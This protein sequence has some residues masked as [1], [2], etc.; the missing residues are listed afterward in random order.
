MVGLKSTSSEEWNRLDN[1]LHEA[2]GYRRLSS[3]VGAGITRNLKTKDKTKEK[4]DECGSVYF[5]AASV[6]S[7]LCPECAHGLYN[8]APCEHK[9]SGGRCTK[10]H[11]DGSISGYLK[12]M[13]APTNS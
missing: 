10:C 4:C 7:Q 5:K 6:M 1:N 11:W 2:T 12:K 9:F 8:Y 13:K 3:N